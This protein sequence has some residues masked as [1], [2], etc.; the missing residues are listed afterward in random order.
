MQHPFSGIL[1]E[2]R[3]DDASRNSEFLLPDTKPED[4]PSRRDALQT[5]LKAGVGVIAGGLAK[6]ATA[7]QPTLGLNETGLPTQGLGETGGVTTNVGETGKLTTK[8]LGEEGSVTTR[9]VGEEGVTTQAIGEEGGV[10]T[11]ALGEEGNA[12]TKAI[13]EEG[14]TDINREQGK[15]NP[16][17]R[18]AIKRA[19]YSNLTEATKLLGRKNWSDA[20]IY[21]DELRKLDDD[22]KGFYSD[23]NTR[24]KKLEQSVTIMVTRELGFADNHYKAG[25]IALALGIYRKADRLDPIYGFDNRVKAALAK[26]KG[27]P[28]YE[29]SLKAIERQES[30]RKKLPA[31]STVSGAEEG[32]KPTTK[33]RGEEGNVTTRARGEEGTI[34]TQALG[35]EGGTLP[36]TQAL[37]EEAG[38]RRPT[39]LAIGEEGGIGTPK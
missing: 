5:V 34:T 39:T 18:A 8:A 16:A 7:Q 4:S 19:A 12:T 24:R 14:T 11:Q 2:T 10:T 26:L 17:E 37:G 1:R 6:A 3:S 35:E 9:A 22:R 36:A 33:A 30:R 20:A 25:K 38:T 31:P 28:N 15:G 21:L 27:H 13:G 23:I 32:G 29:T